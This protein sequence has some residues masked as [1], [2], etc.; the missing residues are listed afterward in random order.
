MEQCE[1]KTA[2]AC[3]EAAT[4]Q[5]TVQAGDRAS[6]RF[7]YYSYWCDGHAAT[8]LEKRRVDRLTPPMMRRM[9]TGTA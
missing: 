9:V 1:S 2:G 3:P 8:I 5:Q 4:W 7:L 6:G